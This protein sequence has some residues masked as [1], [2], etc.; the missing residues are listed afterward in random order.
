MLSNWIDH[1][2]GYRVFYITKWIKKGCLVFPAF[3]SIVQGPNEVELL[4]SSIA[5]EPTVLCLML[6][7]KLMWNCRKRWKPCVPSWRRQRRRG[8][9]WS[10]P[11]T[12]SKHGWV[13]EKETLLKCRCSS[14]SVRWPDLPTFSISSIYYTHA[15]QNCLINHYLRS[16]SPFSLF[17]RPNSLS[18]A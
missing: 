5:T 4:N 7:L 10:L 13:A 1:V 2:I 8:A 12:V 9:S 16:I 11:T 15:R 14:L 3:L 6:G 17:V 18:C